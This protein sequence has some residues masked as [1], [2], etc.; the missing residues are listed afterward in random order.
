MLDTRSP[1]LPSFVT[2]NDSLSFGHMRTLK[3]IRDLVRL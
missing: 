3:N 1:L 2:V